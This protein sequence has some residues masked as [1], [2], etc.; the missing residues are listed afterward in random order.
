MNNPE[1]R[2]RKVLT[3]KEL[4]EADLKM[5]PSFEEKAQLEIWH[6]KK[7]RI[8][9]THQK[10]QFYRL[11]KMVQVALSE[12]EKPKPNKLTISNIEEGIWKL[13]NETGLSIYGSS[14]ANSNCDHFKK[15]VMRHQAPNGFLKSDDVVRVG[16][17]EY[18][19][20]PI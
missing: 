8:P 11:R 5:N 6:L 18:H 1:L 15:D 10:K 17:V 3:D 4:Q 12:L 9:Y 2:K 13:V 19:K 20:I 7:T 16:G 14:I